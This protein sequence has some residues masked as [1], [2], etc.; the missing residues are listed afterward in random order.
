MIVVLVTR[1]LVGSDQVLI[2]P[3][4]YHCVYVQNTAER[5]YSDGNNTRN[6]HQQLNPEQSQTNELVRH[7]IKSRQPLPQL[8]RI[9]E[10]EQVKVG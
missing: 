1:L 9:K 2:H 4:Q 5:L 7:R 3:Q 10:T 6:E 8:D